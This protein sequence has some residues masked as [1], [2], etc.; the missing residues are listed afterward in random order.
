M[1][2]SWK[3]ARITLL[4]FGGKTSHL[5][6]KIQAIIV[7]KFDILI[8]T[9]FNL[10]GVA[11]LKLSVIKYYRKMYR[12]NLWNKYMVSVTFMHFR[13]VIYVYQT[14]IKMLARNKTRCFYLA[15][16]QIWILFYIRPTHIPIWHNIFD[17]TL[18]LWKVHDDDD[19]DVRINESRSRCYFCT[20]KCDSE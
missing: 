2:T 9:S 14:I 20:V 17:K 19:D 4:F 18:N 7:T 1:Q 12:L 15:R 10:F 8:I 13:T 6:Y 3:Y 11:S 5:C 16:N